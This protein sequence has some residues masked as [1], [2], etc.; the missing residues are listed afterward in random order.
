MTVD[1][2]DLELDAQVAL[3]ESPFGGET[4]VRERDAAAAWLLSQPERS[5]P[6]LLTRA[7]Q[8]RAGPATVELL[9]RFGRDDSVPV[10]AELLDR[11]E[12]MGSVAAEALARHPAPAAVAA[13]RDGLRGGGDRAVRSA[14]ALG[15]RGDPAACVDLEA[16]TRDPDQR[17]RYQ[18]VRAAAAPGMNCLS[19][20]ELAEIEASDADED[21]RALAGRLRRQ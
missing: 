17:L 3:L 8:G 15:L 9:G 18:A 6:R 11:E 12:P 2:G 13:L 5:Y 1:P 21:V 16:A 20:A 10:L 19:D 4:D 14:I 7:S